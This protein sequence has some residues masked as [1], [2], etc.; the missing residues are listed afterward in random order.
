MANPNETVEEAIASFFNEHHFS[1]YVIALSGGMDSIALLHSVTQQLPKEVSLKAV[2][3]DHGLQS[4]AQTWLKF[5]QKTC[6]NLQVAFFSKKIEINHTNRKGIE[7]VAREKRYEALFSM[8]E[9]GGCLITGHHQRDQAETFLLSSLRGAGIAGLAGMPL[10]KSKGK[11]FHARPLL[12]VAYQHIQAYVKAHNLHWIED[13]SNQ[14]TKFRRNA[15][16]HKVL[17]VMQAHWDN[18][19]ANLAASA[20]FVGESFE[21]LNQ[22]AEIDLQASEI[23]TL[24]LDYTN[25]KSLNSSRQKNV[26]RFWFHAFLPIQPN[27]L[28]YNWLQEQIDHQK[29]SHPVLKL[30][31]G[32]LRL[33]NN[34]VYY[35][36]EIKDNYS[37]LLSESALQQLELDLSGI[38]D[39]KNYQVCLAG[40]AE[41]ARI[42]PISPTEKQQRKGLKSWF[43]QVKIP[44]WDRKR[45]PVVTLANGEKFVLGFESSQPNE[46]K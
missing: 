2:Y 41:N 3:I 14:D 30:S 8:V 46:A 11:K 36:T 6:Q 37:H 43:K 5:C 29:Q 12:Q 4:E 18:V 39:A 10:L 22:L 25:L 1:S 23:N 7:A 34:K 45:W 40:L 24:Y 9:A 33:Y 35:L 19:E 15:V 26:F 21:L 32:E 20:G 42:S 27:R 28:I 31:C 38:L 16:R 17:P 13:L 44:P